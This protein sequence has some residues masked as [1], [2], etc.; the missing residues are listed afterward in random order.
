MAVKIRLKKFGRRHR[1]CFR[2]GVMDERCPRDGRVIEELGTYDPSNKA[3]EKQVVLIR[4]RIEYWLSVGA[5]PTETVAD[6][7]VKNGI[8][9][10]AA[11]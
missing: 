11:K 2:L 1:N 5:Q 8:S 3:P 4:E 9:L 7:L 10:K 6:L